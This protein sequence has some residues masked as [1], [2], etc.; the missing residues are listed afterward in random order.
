MDE[1]D[2]SN[3]AGRV[4]RDSE[5]FFSRPQTLVR[6][7]N[8]TLSLEGIWEQRIRERIREQTGRSLR[9]CHLSLSSQNDTA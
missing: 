3:E 8:S 4:M 7:R 1:G 9:V 5:W 6:K 2:V